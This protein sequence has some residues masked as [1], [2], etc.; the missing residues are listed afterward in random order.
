MAVLRVRIELKRSAQGIEM[1][2]LKELSEESQKFLRMVAEDVG[3]NPNEG[4]WIA[5]DFYNQGIGFN[6]E[7]QQA[8]I[9]SQLVA[10]YIHAID[11]IATVTAETNWSVRGVRPQTIVQ[12]ARVAKIADDG[13][14][15]RLGLL[16]G[17]D[18]IEW[19]P[20]P[21]DRAAAVIEHFNVWAEYRGMLQG[22]ILTI[23]KESSPSYFTLRDFASGQTVRCE[24]DAN[25]WPKLHKAIERKE[26]PV[27]VSGWIRTRRMD[28]KIDYLRVERVQGTKPLSRERLLKFFGSAPGWT[29]DLTTDQ[30]IDSIR[31]DGDQ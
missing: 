21:L 11:G 29:G 31:D 22:M 8:E 13:E 14:V 28:R 25:D 7:F 6:A 26:S 27:F 9:D 10:S 3:L 18:S 5:K 20:L 19:R 17:A 12:A 15:V 4:K 23:F 2:K 16:N 30:F 24:F 1:S